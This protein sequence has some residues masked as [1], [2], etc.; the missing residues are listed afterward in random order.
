M[1]AKV[2]DK[3][4]FRSDAAYKK[5][6]KNFPIDGMNAD[7][8]ENL[9]MPHP[10]DY[11]SKKDFERDNKRWEEEFQKAAGSA[12]LRARASGKIVNPRPNKDLSSGESIAA[13]VAAIR[14]VV[15][16]RS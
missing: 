15:E 6:I 4:L 9:R 11:N 16:K 14:S 10:F 7:E 13:K 1:K 5:A 8:L 3:T 12:K 2:S